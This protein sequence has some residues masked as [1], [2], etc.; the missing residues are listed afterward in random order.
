MNEI[1]RS[2]L[3]RAILDE[4][5]GLNCGPGQPVPVK[6]IWLRLM[7]QGFHQSEEFREA[8]VWASSGDI[9]LI[10]IQPGGIA[11]LGSIVLTDNGYLTSRG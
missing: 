7:S 5:V 6:T 10:E 8:L 1:R 2:E 11:G 9:P 4:L 3:V